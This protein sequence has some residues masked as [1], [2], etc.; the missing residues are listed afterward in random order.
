[1]IRTQNILYFIKGVNDMF[2]GY[3]MPG[4]FEP[5]QAVCATW[6]SNVP[7][8]GDNDPGNACAQII[9]NLYKRIQVYINC[10]DYV[11]RMDCEKHLKAAEVELGKIK[12]FSWPDTNF[13]LR[14]NG[15]NVMFNDNGEML[16]ID[17]NFNFYGMFPEVDAKDN[18]ARH[19]G[20]HFA[21]AAGCTNIL[22][23]DNRD[24][25]RKQR[26]QR[27]RRPYPCRENRLQ[28]KEPQ[29]HKG[30]H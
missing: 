30:V 17:T 25:G 16:H 5:Q 10:V 13:Y 23:T 22:P 4:E 20:T 8:I 1:M 29:I 2:E 19:A 3:R 7:V 9:K 24:R 14:D 18:V 15:P 28:K 27:R 26:I 21:V 11:T 12:F 6:I